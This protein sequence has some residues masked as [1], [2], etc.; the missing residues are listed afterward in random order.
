MK[1][2]REIYKSI[3]TE[4]NNP[5]SFLRDKKIDE[6]IYSQFLIKSMPV[7]LKGVHETVVWKSNLPSKADISKELH[8]APATQQRKL[9]QLMNREYIIEDSDRQ[10]INKE[11][12]ADGYVPTNLELLK[13]M[14]FCFAAPII[15]AYCFLQSRD[16][17]AKNVLGRCQSFTLAELGAESGCPVNT[18]SK[19]QEKVNLILQILVDVGLV[20]QEKQFD[21]KSPRLRLIRVNEEFHHKNAQ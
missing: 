20:E 13:D 10:I 5:L 14:T 1:E 21:G 2:D 7:E 18:S 15:K 3:P 9:T 6:R 8:M 19:S 16:K 11:K 12:L 17:Q 4:W